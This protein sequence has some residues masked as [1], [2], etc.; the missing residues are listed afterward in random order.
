MPA[1]VIK[2]FGGL[3][4]LLDPLLLQQGD[5]TVANNVRLLS[6]SLTPLKGTSILKSLTKASP[7]TIFRYGTSSAEDEH[8]L[9][10]TA[11]TDVIRSPIAD[12]DYGRVYWA[13]GGTAK[14]A[15]S[16]LILAGGSL[17]GGSYTLGLPA[18]VSAPSATQTTFSPASGTIT[19]AQ[20]QSLA[21]GNVLSI[22]VNGGS[23]V[24]LTLTGSGGTVTA[25]TLAD[26]IGTISGLS[27]TVQS[28]G[29]L[30]QTATTTAAS[31]LT[32]R[33]QV[34]AGFVDILTATTASASST[35]VRVYVYTYVSAYGEEGPPSSPSSLLTTAGSGTVSVSGMAVGPGGSYNITKKRLYRSSTVGS[36]AQYQF[37]A[38][39]P[40]ATTSYSD[41]VTQ[42]NL[43][44]VLPSQ[45]WVAPPSGLRGLKQLA[46]GAAIGFVGNTAYLSEPNL[47]HAWPHQYPIDETIV[48]I[49]VFRQSAVLLTNGHPYLMSGADPQAM[50]TE[51]MELPQA[52][53]SKRSIVDTGEGVL[54]ASPDGIVSIGAGGVTL[55]TRDLLSREQWQAY[56]PSSMEAAFHDNRYHVT[57]QTT[58]GARG[59]LI[60][61]FS[62][63]GAAM[64]TSDVNATS[65][66]TAMFSDPRTDTL[67]MAQGASLVRFNSGAASTYTWRSKRFRTPFHMNFGK[68]QVIAV[69][70][71]VTLKVYGDGVLRFTKSVLNNNIFHLPG[72]Y[73]SLDWQL[74]VSGTAEVTQVAMATSAEEIRMS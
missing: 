54:Y 62:G 41:S 5:A 26:Q 46:N 67:Y 72:G 36:Q 18:P 27:A 22:T 33:K 44:E 31:S 8:W 47:P 30:V 15:P 52:C 61:D 24:T 57:Y 42:A 11:D 17:P 19:A 45:D 16:N 20:V 56:N 63:Q 34:T 74:E 4:P 43:G 49:G 40:L 9:E 2:A 29:V 35:E 21:V 71:P 66:V 59:M 73:R 10:F 6:G 60:F 14:Y 68:A 50:S 53:V 39:I 69:S 51:K 37:V 1:I 64:T 12:D 38:E 23:A 7:K 58:A 32:I 48:G 55:A 70:Y 13:D 28:G 65:Q 25:T 3:K